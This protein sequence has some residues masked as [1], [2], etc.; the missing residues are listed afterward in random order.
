MFIIVKIKNNYGKDCIY[1][2]CDTAKVFAKL[3][4]TT[5]LTQESIGMIRKLGYEIRVEPQVLV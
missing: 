3:C 1:P 2:I 4:G 5:T